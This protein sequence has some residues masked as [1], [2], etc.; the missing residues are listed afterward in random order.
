MLGNLQLSQ[1]NLPFFNSLKENAVR[2]YVN[3]SV[4]GGGTAN[5]EFEALT[6]CTMGFFPTGYYAYQQCMVKPIN[7]LVSNME[8]AG[9]TSYSIHPE[10]ASNWNRDRVYQYFGFDNSYWIEDFPGA[11]K[12]HYGVSDL[13]T[14]RFVENLFEN[15]QKGEKLFIFN[16]TVQNHGG[17][18]SDIDVTVDAQNASTSEA[19][20]YLSLIKESDAAFE[21]LI[22]YFE[23][24]QEKV[25]I[26]M[27]GDHQPK[28]ADESFYDAVYMQTEGLS[29]RDKKLNLYKTPFI[30]WANY[31]IPE[32]EGLDIGMSYLGAL[33]LKT[34]QIPCSPF[35]TF[36]Q[37]EMERYPIVTVNGFFDKEGGYYDWP[38]E[39]TQLLEYRILQYNYLFDSHT[40]EWGF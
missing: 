17:Y 21:Q 31:D 25:I 39:Q 2:G 24:Q 35:Y 37:Q 34:A 33:L 36:L 29:E 12:I 19:D 3:A 13:E 15:R 20:V 40:V 14:Y 32:A 9:Y 7:S 10:A 16:L 5:S 22:D 28:L 18:G 38:Q 1:E 4:L 26:C 23:K 8:A 30:I 27:F 6:G 11:E